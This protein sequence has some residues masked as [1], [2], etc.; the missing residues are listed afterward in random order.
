MCRDGEMMR[1]GGT[2]ER[3]GRLGA[4]ADLHIPPSGHE[5]PF[6]TEPSNRENRNS[7]GGLELGLV[8]QQIMLVSIE[9][10]GGKGRRD[11]SKVEFSNKMSF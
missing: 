5:I 4:K 8:H 9:L 2:V 1:R 10:G 7:Y 11:S 3:R 6:M